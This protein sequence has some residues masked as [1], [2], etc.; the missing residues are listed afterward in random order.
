M[1]AEKRLF[2]KEMEKKI[3]VL[4]QEIKRKKELQEI[5][6]EFVIKELQN[7]LNKNHQAKKFISQPKPLNPKSAQYKAIIKEVRAKLRVV[8]GLFREE[9]DLDRREELISSLF[10][11]TS[12]TI[13]PTKPAPMTTLSNKPPLDP[14]IIIEILKT[15][16]S[17]KERAALYEKLYQNIFEITGT[18]KTI[19]DLGC[20]IN[21]FSI[22][23]MKVDS[24]RYY[25]YDLSVEE[26]ESLNDFFR[27][28]NKINPNL[29][30]K[31]EVL[32]LL[33][34]SKLPS[35]EV[36]F[37]FKMTDVLEHGKGHKITESIIKSIPASFIV[38]SFPIKTM[39]GK[40]MNFPRRRWIEL[41][42]KRLNYSY[43]LLELSNEL[44]YVIKK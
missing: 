37:L 16:S 23:L 2:N 41:M 10:A 26:I 25:A 44:F 1:T 6:A 7:Y 27:S 9:H 11:Q 13:L 8:Y 3:H 43:Q 40:R 18:P 34:F 24:L 15:H 22:P 14:Q 17:T 39:S 30:G 20:G 31:A 29:I 19:L 5:S 38:I 21:P 32:D 36:C 35:A 12:Q 42:C 28:L 4:L 33:Q